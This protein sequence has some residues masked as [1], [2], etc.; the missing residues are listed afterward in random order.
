M[1]KS[2]QVI[3]YLRVSV[4]EDPMVL[5]YDEHIQDY[6]IDYDQGDCHFVVTYEGKPCIKV[7]YEDCR[8]LRIRRVFPLGEREDIEDQQGRVIIESEA[9]FGW[10]LGST[11]FVAKRLLDLNRLLTDINDRARA[12]KTLGPTFNTQMNIFNSWEEYLIRR[13][14]GDANAKGF[15]FEV[16]DTSMLP[17]WE[18]VKKY[19]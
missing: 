10:L 5:V 8:A 18:S 3:D 2:G 14:F 17:K 1:K 9:A 19:V 6:A 15:K 12:R 4:S 16:V 7:R 13:I 11:S